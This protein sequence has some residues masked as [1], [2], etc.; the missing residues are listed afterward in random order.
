MTEKK[1][2][3]R[4]EFDFKQIRTEVVRK[5]DDL[6]PYERNPR[7][8]ADALPYL[9]ESIRQFGMNVPIVIDKHNVVVCGHTRLRACQNLGFTEVKCVLLDDLSPTQIK[10]FRLA[11]NKI[12]EYS[13][14]DF[15][16]LGLEEKDIAADL[17]ADLDMEDFGFLNEP[18]PDG[19]DDADPE[20]I[21]ST[22]EEEEEPAEIPAEED[23]KI[24]PGDLV[25]IGAHRI[26]CGDSTDPAVLDRLMDG[27][28]AAVCVTSPPYNIGRNL[29]M[30]VSIKGARPET[31]KKYLHDRDSMDGKEYAEFLKKDVDLLLGRASEVFYNIGLLS[32]TK[33][34]VLKLLDH[35]AAYWKD[36]LYYQKK[37]P[38]PV[39]AKNVISTAVEPIFAFGRNGSRAF[40]HDPGI[41]DGVILGSAT[42]NAY[43][44][45]HRATFCKELPAEIIGHFTDEGETVLDPFLGTGT[46]LIA[47]AEAG[48]ICYGA[49]LEPLYV[50][51][52]VER[53]LKDLGEAAGEVTVVR[54][55][56]ELRWDEL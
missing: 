40:R 21:V 13:G 52:S 50:Q 55:G 20:E 3:K 35:E 18:V 36:T 17:D 11:D 41:W 6:K 47:A 37:N 32:S 38:V 10:A 34:P 45:I 23:V 8:N 15:D 16:M 14:W 9:E 39:A 2:E 25:K 24:H 46:T 44:K 33:I 51:V 42:G 49:D 19:D 27:T 56:K 26:I 7:I 1:A 31:G 5:L 12:P 22:V 30:T 28:E 4:P 48:R 43:G 53:Y 29:S 54:D